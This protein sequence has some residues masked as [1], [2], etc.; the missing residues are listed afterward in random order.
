MAKTGTV[1]IRA[2]A[3]TTND[4]LVSL[5]QQVSD[6]VAV[7]KASHIWGSIKENTQQNDQRNDNKNRRAW[8]FDTNGHFSSTGSSEKNQCMQP[9]GGQ[10][11]CQ[12]YHCWG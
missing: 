10:Y 12:C 3:A 8:I 2:K 5:K 11:A 4:E 6:V 7:V 1:I 9:L